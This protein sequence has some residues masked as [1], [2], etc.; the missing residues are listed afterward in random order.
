MN[1]YNLHTPEHVDTP[2]LLVYPD[3]IQHNIEALK[4]MIDRVDRLRPH[5]KTHKTKEIT[6][7]QLD[8]GI[9]KFKCATIA[10]A[11]MLGECGVPDVLLAYPLYG[12]KLQR[13]VTL[14]QHF[15]QTRF[16]AIVDHVDAVKNLSA[17]A[18]QNEIQ[19]DVF[20]DLNIGMGRTGIVP[21]DAA[22]E[23]YRFCSGVDGLN[24]KGLHAYDGHVREIN[25]AERKNICD[26]NYEPIA[27]LIERLL[28]GGFE[29]PSVV[30][31]GSPSFPIYAQYPEVECSPGTF[32]LW[33]KGYADTLPE[34][35]FLPAAVLMTRVVSLPSENT[36]C[37][38][39]GYKAIAS[40]NPLAN[41]VFF[42]NASHLK[43]ISHS[44]EHL[45]LE[46][47]VNHHFQVG[48]VLYALPI[49]ICPT[50]ALYDKLLVV[51]NNA[52]VGEWEVVARRR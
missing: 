42:L 43:P 29:K 9:R 3:R 37:V 36:I 49:H 25:I 46:A 24:V 51:E 39:L 17:I 8:A 34:Q 10:E 40:E 22:F 19:I 1:W 50:V 44:E 26:R 48:D 14:V 11:E 18:V 6:R 13:F 5:V 30:I 28:D 2:A 45:V 27:K 33:D 23:L 15:P 41:R 38:D 7:M 47:G 31:G 21:D 4:G 35:N 32:V 52:V 16:S 12:A 20:I